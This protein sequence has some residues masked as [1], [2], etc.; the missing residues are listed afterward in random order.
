MSGV[1]LSCRWISLGWHKI[2][3]VNVKKHRAHERPTFPR[4]TMLNPGMM[5]K[6]TGYVMIGFGQKSSTVEA[7]VR[8]KQ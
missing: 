2:G 1:A 8:R 5:P 4:K 3:K 7:I 6:G